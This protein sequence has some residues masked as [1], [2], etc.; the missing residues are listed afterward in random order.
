MPG[1]LSASTAAHCISV[2]TPA[3]LHPT[4][5]GPDGARVRGHYPPVVAPLRGVSVRPTRMQTKD[6][7]RVKT[8]GFGDRGR[9]PTRE[10]G[11]PG[12]C[13][14]KAPSRADGEFLIFKFSRSTSRT[15]P[16]PKDKSRSAAWGCAAGRNDERLCLPAR[17]RWCLSGWER[18][19]LAGCCC[20]TG[21]VAPKRRPA[22]AGRP[23][24]PGVSCCRRL[25]ALPRMSTRPKGV[26]QITPPTGDGPYP[27]LGPWVCSDAPLARSSS[28]SP[29]QRWAF[30]SC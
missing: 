20:S 22:A 16:N 23:G 3:V 1:S 8:G 29:A 9:P 4:P 17:S 28:T 21:C 27:T 5:I 30:L 10:E 6:G 26:T 13:R 11:V 14:P 24:C 2:S 18:Q 25:L 12:P 7:P 15:K 19:L